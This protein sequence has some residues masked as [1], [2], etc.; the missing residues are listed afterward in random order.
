MNWECCFSEG[1]FLRKPYPVYQT[2]GD[3][4]TLSWHAEVS[5]C[6]GDATHRSCAQMSRPAC[7]WGLKALHASGLSPCTPLWQQLCSG[8]FGPGLLDLPV[9]GRVLPTWCRFVC[10]PYL[11]LEVDCIFQ[12]LDP[13]PWK[14]EKDEKEE[15][16][17]NIRF[18]FVYLSE[19]KRVNPTCH[20]T[21]TLWLQICQSMPK[22]SHLSLATR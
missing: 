16:T 17:K 10:K 5:L 13:R 19:K 20:P 18:L 9:P 12:S 8:C 11:S 7:E 2:L 21:P 3:L 4:C 22:P 1:D 6:G 14:S 15:K